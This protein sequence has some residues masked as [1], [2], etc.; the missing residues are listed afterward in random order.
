[1]SPT[2]YSEPGLRPEKGKAEQAARTGPAISPSDRVRLY[3]GKAPELTR[4][5]LHPSVTYADDKDCGY[6]LV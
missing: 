3:A 5:E 2:S 6:V 4:F 1:M